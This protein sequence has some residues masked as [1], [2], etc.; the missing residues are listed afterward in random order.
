MD[1]ASFYKVFAEN[2][3]VYYEGGSI[4]DRL[5]SPFFE[6]KTILQFAAWMLSNLRACA[7]LAPNLSFE[8]HPV[9]GLMVKDLSEELVVLV[10]KAE[11]IDRTDVEE[12]VELYRVMAERFCRGDSDPFGF[13][14]RS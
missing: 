1:G 4:R 5:S 3:I 14:R 9:L 12:V 8:V 10:A 2:G 11:G 13:G 7:C 6:H